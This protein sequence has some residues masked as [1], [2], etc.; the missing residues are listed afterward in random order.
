[1]KKLFSVI[2][3]ISAFFCGI[4]AQTLFDNENNRRHFGLRAGV[5][6]SSAS[7]TKGVYSNRA[8][9]ELSLIY[10]LPVYKNF[11]FEPG[12]G[13]F[14]DSFG[15][16]QTINYFDS[17]TE[18]RYVINNSG[19]L[20]NLGFRVPFNFGFHFDIKDNLAIHIFTGPMMNFSF[21]ARYSTDIDYPKEMTVE[22]FKKIEDMIFKGSAFGSG[23]FRNFD[24]QWNIGVGL[25][26][27]RLYVSLSGAPGITK[28]VK[29]NEYSFR[30]NLFQIKVGYDF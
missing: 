30:R 5:D 14:F 25:S 9:Y 16:D 10:H 1:M 19:S 8:G 17:E 20:K 3:L 26:I 12:F 23:G 7:E 21:R 27:N 24:L 6:V 2:I 15:V 29:N 18:G 22:Q 13:F 11:Y 28:L 4:N